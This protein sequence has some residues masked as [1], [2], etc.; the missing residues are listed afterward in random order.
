[1]PH[2]RHLAGNLS[3]CI[4]L[5]QWIAK[6]PFISC[7]IAVGKEED[8][9]LAADLNA[10]VLLVKSSCD[11][12]YTFLPE[13]TCATTEREL[14]EVLE[15][16]RAPEFPLSPSTSATINTP[17]FYTLH[18]I[19]SYEAVLCPTSDLTRLAGHLSTI[20]GFK[21][22]SLPNLLCE[23]TRCC[24]LAMNEHDGFEVLKW[25]A[26]TL[27]KLP[28][29]FSL[30]LTQCP[31]GDEQGVVHTALASLLG[32]TS[33][34]DTTDARCKANCFEL[35]VRS[36][37]LLL[38]ESEIEG[39]VSHRRAQLEKRKGLDL[40]PPLESRD[41]N[42]TI[43]AD[44]TLETILKTFDNRS[45]EQSEF[46]NL[47]SV[48]FHII[49]GSSFDLLLS[50]S[51]ANGTLAALVA[52][53]LMFNDGCKESQGE[54]VKVSQNRAALFDM[55]FL[56]LVYMV[57]C[58]G[59]EVVLKD[60]QPCFFSQWAKQCM[61]E[62][63][64]VKPLGNFTAQESLVD[65]LLQ[66]FTQ[67]EVRTQVVKWNSVCSSVHGVMSELLLAAELGAL[68][69]ADFFKLTTKLY[70]QLCCF[71]VCIVSWLAS[72]THFGEGGR[73]GGKAG[74]GVTPFQVVDRF[75][76]V[77]PDME[78]GESL[79]YFQQ[80]S[81]MMVNIVRRMKQEMV[82]GGLSTSVESGWGG[83]PRDSMALE[84][85]F[86][87]LWGDTWSR[88]RLDIIGTRQM[89]RL[90][91]IGGPA[92]MVRAAVEQLGKQ[93]YGEDVSKATELVFSILHIDLTAS[94]LALL[95]QVLPRLLAGDGRD[96][97]LAFPTGRAL[98]KL[99]V[100]CLAAALAN[101]EAPPYLE[102]PGRSWALESLAG[103][104]QPAKMRR[105]NTGEARPVAEAAASQEELVEQAH[106]GLFHLLSS[107]GQE[108]V[109]TPKL[110]FLAS[111]LEEA[112]VGGKEQA[113]AVL[114]PLPAALLSQVVKVQPDRFSLPMVSK[115]FD[116]SV[117]AG[118]KT[119]ARLLCLMRNMKA[120]KE[121][122]EN[123][124]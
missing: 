110:E 79:Q 58:F 65:S 72:Y 57:Q 11:Q 98:A 92:W 75:L 31:G 20:L 17:L 34:L 45:T 120:G 73:D 53:L 24:L 99:T 109:L 90:L 14:R 8:S 83:G 59:S 84:A 82:R 36:M 6:E 43:K 70:T 42:L 13:A 26:F 61:V 62:P 46:E 116:N 2:A 52:K 40:K 9:E 95:T 105:G 74:D 54:S 103:S 121:A 41:I 89:A 100:Q 35:V 18:S 23:V 71:P 55:T 119:T 118:R 44:S 78:D 60:T 21:G 108:P 94:T 33:L 111:L 37:K 32:Y 124:I 107:I 28:R 88:G 85:E 115:M 25:D 101:R 122:E 102:T 76:D 12:L 49:K 77:T 51:A 27:I 38:S 97:L 56:M 123:E 10:A 93:V 64:A 16:L 15:E 106:Q 67:G 69:K 86:A 22:T 87:S 113:R 96:G 19:I 114:Q 29:L 4:A 66:Q 81:S 7:L 112:V 117:Q 30:L 3:S 68:S 39:L 48:M 91:Q 104:K 80:R 47:L 63:G 50:A 1:V 5:L